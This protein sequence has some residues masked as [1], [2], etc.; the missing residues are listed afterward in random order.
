M[1]DTQFNST[2]SMVDFVDVIESGLV[3]SLL[4]NKCGWQQL[5]MVLRLH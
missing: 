5:M 4:W 2:I 1:Q 3:F